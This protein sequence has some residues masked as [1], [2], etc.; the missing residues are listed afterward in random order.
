LSGAIARRLSRISGILAALP[1]S[2]IFRTVVP[3]LILGLFYWALFVNP[4]GVRGSSL[5]SEEARVL[6]DGSKKLFEEG[7]Y[8]EALGPVLK[9]YH[10]Y[11]DSHIYAEQVAQ[12]FHK[13]HRYKEEAEL[14]EEF[15]ENAPRPEEACPHI[16][17]AYEA[18]GSVS[19]AI[20]GYEWCLAQDPS[21]ADSVFYLA[22]AMERDGQYARAGDLYRRGLS[23][24]PAYSDLSIGLA[25]VMLHQSRVA[26]AKAAISDV[27]QRQPKNSDALYIMGMIFFRAG[28]LTQAR[29]YLENGAF[30]AD[31]N[32]DFH[33]ALAQLS[34]KENNIPDAIMHYSRAVE[35]SPEDKELRA[36]RD[37]LVA[38]R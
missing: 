14:W 21:N 36:R 37:S 35:L 18:L 26:E 9:L 5:T 16:G 33:V 22:H 6:V 30:Q 23:L 1:A 34:E 25:R 7:K 27:L 3:L 31:G 38:R 15:R 24:A 29:Q 11:P 13:L 8:E 17:Q 28:D 20:S 10:A 2:P 32:P 19:E 12:I 4:G